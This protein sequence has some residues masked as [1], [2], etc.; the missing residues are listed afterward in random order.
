MEGRRNGSGAG[1]TVGKLP[2]R[3]RDTVLDSRR[4]MK[5][6]LYRGRPGNGAKQAY[7]G[8]AAHL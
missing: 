5:A 1:V 7:Q 4:D 8:L 3:N 6:N 2:G